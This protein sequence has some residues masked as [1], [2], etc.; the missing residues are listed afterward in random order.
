MKMISRTEYTDTCPTA[1]HLNGRHNILRRN[2][3]RWR[4]SRY[5]AFKY[6]H[7]SPDGQCSPPHRVI[8]FSIL[9]LLILARTSE[10]YAPMKLVIYYDFSLIFRDASRKFGSAGRERRCNIEQC[11]SIFGPAV[12]AARQG[13]FYT[14]YSHIWRRKQLIGRAK[15]NRFPCPSYRS[16]KQA[17]DSWWRFALSVVMFLLVT[18]TWEILATSAVGMSYLKTFGLTRLNH[19]RL[20]DRCR[21]PTYTQDWDWTRCDRHHDCT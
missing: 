21:N 8:E 2:L 5:P 3:N 10:R 15:T 6:Y 18:D 7:N 11:A 12:I 13:S 4:Q 9:D 20:Q 17:S 14:W 16:Q 19:S 1:L